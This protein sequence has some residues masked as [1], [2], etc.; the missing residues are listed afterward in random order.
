MAVGEFGRFD[1]E[2]RWRSREKDVNATLE[3]DV[4]EGRHSS[5]VILDLCLLFRLPS[6]P[7]PVLPN[8]VL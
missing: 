4:K 3:E 6:N 1:V 2:S 8:L 5:V 7:P